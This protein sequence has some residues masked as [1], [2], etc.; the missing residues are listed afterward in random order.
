MACVATRLSSAG[1][2]GPRA[3][4]NAGARDAGHGGGSGG[5]GSGDGGSGDG[6][7]DNDNDEI[8]SA[9][10]YSLQSSFHSVSMRS[11]SG[12]ASTQTTILLPLH[13]AAI[14]G[15]SL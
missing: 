2:V 7:D 4:S 8:N 3:R 6:Y 13:I 14:H 9:M 11:L 12:T 15:I 5:G 10:L 1:V